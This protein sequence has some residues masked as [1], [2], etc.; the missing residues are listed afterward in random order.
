MAS[1]TEEVIVKSIT[2]PVTISGNV[3]SNVGNVIVSNVVVTKITSP[4]EVYGNVGLTSNI[5]ISNVVVSK[6]TS[7]V[8]VFGLVGLASDVQITN[9]IV[10]DVTVPVQVYG[11]VGFVP[12]ATISN[13]VVSSVQTPVQVYGNVG[14]TS[15][16][17]VSNVVV[18]NVQTPV[19]VYG[20]VGFDENAVLSNVVITR[21]SS[22]VQ[23]YGNIGFSNNT[24]LSNV[25]VSSIQSPVLVYGNVGI[26]S[27]VTFANVVVSEVTNPV[28]VYGNVGL[29]NPISLQNV[30]IANVQTPVL[31]YGNV[32]VLDMKLSNV[33]VS[34]IAEPVEIYGNV[35][36]VS[37]I[38]L[39]NLTIA[40]VN[41][42][43]SVIGNV[44]IANIFSVSNVVVSNVLVPV[45]V[46]G[47]VDLG[48][49]SIVTVAN[50]LSNVTVTGDVTLS[51]YTDASG[52]LSISQAYPLLEAKFVGSIGDP[53]TVTTTTGT[54]VV[55]YDSNRTSMTLGLTS[56]VG[57]ALVRT[58]TRAVYQTGKSLLSAVGF[59]FSDAQSNLV[60]RVGYYDD[61]NGIFLQSSGSVISI[62]RRS[63]ASGSVVDEVVPRSNWNVDKF[64]GTGPSGIN[65]NFYGPQTFICELVYVGV[66]RAQVGIFGDGVFRVAHVFQSTDGPAYSPILGNATLPVRWETSSSGALSTTAKLEAFGCAVGLDGGSEPRG[67]LRTVESSWDVGPNEVVEILAVRV[68]SSYSEFASAAVQRISMLTSSGVMWRLVMNATVTSPGVWSNA[69]EDGSSAIEFTTTRTSETGT[70]RIIASGFISGSA[71]SQDFGLNEFFSGTGADG[72]SDVISLEITGFNGSS[73]TWR[74]SMSVKEII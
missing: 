15:S 51:S 14:L 1:W 26:T 23:I 39:S 10:T 22:P 73:D 69:A 54:G 16:L 20:N 46:F 18:S 29:T 60:Q 56:G 45:E 67:V 12:D 61:K 66:G 7:P 6:V 38:V 32:G 59:S 35:G 8:E 48:P 55:T 24:V 58:R 27:N 43:V 19:R 47:N 3:S 49:N 40:N 42:I 52:R 57:T 4:V 68:R 65:S 9:V 53:R 13:V 30:S 62:V 33:S 11:N 64:D 34:N 28:Q 17:S 25:V 74:A 31:V 37:N 21:V 41:T 5:A 71:M 70:G 63:T 72:K 50:V 2:L 36:L 44:S